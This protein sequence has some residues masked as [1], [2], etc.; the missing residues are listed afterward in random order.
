MATYK[1]RG[2]SHSVV[3]RYIDENGKK[4]QHWETYQTELEALQ[5]KVYIDCLQKE[6]KND[7]MRAAARDY[8][9]RRAAVKEAI[10]RARGAFRPV[11]PK[12]PPKPSP[13]GEDNSQKTFRDFMERFLPIHA[14]K[15]RFSPNS[16]DS[17]RTTLKTHIYPYFGDWVM[18]SIK[19]EDIDLFVDYLSGKRCS[20]SKAYS[21]DPFKI[22]HLSQSTIKKCYDV[23]TVGFP[24][25]K[26]WGYIKEIPVTSAPS[27][28]M[29]KRRAWDAERVMD[30]MEK[31][32][33]DSL[34]H[35][36]VHLAFVCSLRAGEVV[37]IEASSVNFEDKSLWITQ[38]VERVSDEAIGQL[39]K[40]DLIKIFPKLKEN[41][42]SSIILKTPKTEGSVRKQYLTWPLLAEIKERMQEIERNKDFFGSEYQ[43][44]GLLICNPDGTPIEP[45]S[46]N[47]KLKEAEMALGIEDQIEFQGLRKSGQMHK[48]RLTQ[49]NYQLVAE[50]AGQSPEVLMSNYNEALDSEKRELA[51]LVEEH[52][53]PR[54]VTEDGK[55]GDN[56]DSMTEIVEKIRSDPKFSQQIL[57]LLLSSAANAG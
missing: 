39:P 5:R 29:K 20:G 17:Y 38:I 7:E 42:K 24:T 34:L 8:K 35:L 22:P 31:I 55:R 49:N 57:Q 46:L 18:S 1:M 3:Y 13:S 54:L 37:G 36:E 33:R 25:A 43:D 23:L 16:Y 11:E 50:N 14:R 52:L 53:Y 28:K 12:E 51:Q 40:E 47:G 26:I 19:A 32:P 56:E 48:V 2:D 21:D 45:K 44:Y 15:E 9:A 30:L 4:I 6:N 27:C 10:Q 41:S